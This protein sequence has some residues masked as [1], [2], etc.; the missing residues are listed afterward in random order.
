[1]KNAEKSP[2]ALELKAIMDPY[3][4]GKGKGSEPG[5]KEVYIRR[6]SVVA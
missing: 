1:M 4:I 3:Q 6:G 2:Y 5:H